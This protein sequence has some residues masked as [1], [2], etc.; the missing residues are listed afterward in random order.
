MRDKI[1][2][3]LSAFSP[4]VFRPLTI[5]GNSL[6]KRESLFLVGVLFLSPQNFSW[7]FFFLFLGKIRRRC[8][9]LGVSFIGEEMRRVGRLK[10][11]WWYSHGCRVRRSTW[12]TMCSSTRLWVG[13]PSFAIQNFS[14]CKSTYP[15]FGIFFLRSSNF[16]CR[17]D[18]LML[19][20]VIQGLGFIIWYLLS[21]LGLTQL[22]KIGSLWVSEFVI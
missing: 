7:F 15:Q 14:M 5:P 20:S 8:G 13:I 6:V 10:E 1:R 17:F 16:F 12:R 19:W 11:S 21:P 18:C 4:S 3:R 2:K 22:P 9:G